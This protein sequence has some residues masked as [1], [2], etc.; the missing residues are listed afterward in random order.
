MLSSSEP[1]P[2]A[3]AVWTVA[4]RLCRRPVA[5]LAPV[6]GGGN[7]RLYRI[8][9]AD[10]RFALKCYG[11]IDARGDRLGNEFDGLRFLGAAGA[12]AIPT[13][14]T[15]DRDRRVAL[16]GWI[17]GVA[18]GSEAGEGVGQALEF[19]AALHRIGRSHGGGWTGTATEA[20][21]S[22]RELLRQIDGRLARLAALDGDAELARFLNHDL[23]PTLE[24]VAARMEA[25]YAA[26]S[27][28]PA[29]D[30]PPGVRVLSPS[31]FGFHNAVR[32]PDGRLVF[33]DFEYFGWDDPVKLTADL[34]WH[35]GMRLGGDPARAWLSGAV[36]LF[37]D[38]PAF[39]VRLSAQLPL[40]G[41]RWCLIVL[42]EFLPE[43]WERRLYAGS[44]QA[45]WERAKTTQLAKA[46]ALLTRVSR[47]AVI[48]EPPS[49]S[50]FSSPP[51]SPLWTTDR[52]TSGTW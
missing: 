14:L 6:G 13:A 1:D 7:N 28:D 39:A 16:Y 19:V 45:D 47:L 32:R 48:D 33:V 27:L 25:L 44:S 21:L 10:S 52:A 17:D 24:Q 4:E 42:N 50:S 3:H 23:A 30:I 46:R 12:D 18:A 40:F 31:D 43:R 5:A 41:L 38:D 8:D 35:P 2:T 36:G 22:A 9:T 15:A 26:A 51:W 49:R 11:P 20:C 34:L 37:G 29:A